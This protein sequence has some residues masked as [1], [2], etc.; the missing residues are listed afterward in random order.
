MQLYWLCLLILIVFFV[1]SLGF[2]IYSIM[3][4]T[5][6]DCFTTSLPIW[7][8]FISFSYLTAVVRT[9]RIRLNKSGKSRHSCLVPYLRGNSFQ[10]FSIEYDVSWGFVINGLYYVEICSL[11]INFFWEFLLW[12][13]IEFCQNLFLLILYFVTGCYKITG[14]TVIVSLQNGFDY[15]LT[16]NIVVE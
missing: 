11:Y 10:L 5:N 2:S 4:S 16:Y 1:K 3:Q 6:S 14:I 15:M 9:S 7:M 13:D 8:L 12:M